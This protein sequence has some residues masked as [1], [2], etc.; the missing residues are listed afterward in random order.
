[1]RTSKRTVPGAH[2][3]AAREFALGQWAAIVGAHIV[4]GEVLAVDVEER[5]RPPVHFG[6][7]LSTEWNFR[8]ARL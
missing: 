7:F 6:Q 3:L 2:D 5:D 8:A 4:D 1:M